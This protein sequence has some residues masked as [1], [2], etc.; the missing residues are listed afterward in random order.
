M[1][2]QSW[3]QILRRFAGRGVCPY[4]AGWTLVLPLRRLILSP[5]QLADRLHLRDDMR[6]LELGCGPGYFSQEVARRLHRGALHL[7][8]LQPEMLISARH[9]AEAKAPPSLSFTQGNGLCLPF[10]GSAFDVVFLVTVLGEMPDASACLGEIWR[11]LR[12]GG[13]LSI[14][15]QPGDPDFMPL[16][17][18]EA[19]AHQHGFALEA[20]YGRGLHYT[21]NFRKTSATV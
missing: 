18:V 7:F 15:E 10:R 21:A 13:L 8:D 1:G 5:E 12:P 20:S 3:Q 4:Q 2:M 6:V 9:R 17:K 16:P 14:T 19:L 11:T